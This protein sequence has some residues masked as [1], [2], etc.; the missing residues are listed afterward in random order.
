MSVSSI[1]GGPSSYRVPTSVEPT[2]TAASLATAKSLLESH[3]A[4]A[5]AL[6]NLTGRDG[7]ET[8]LGTSPVSQPG[9]IQDHKLA[10]LKQMGDMML[11]L[12][13]MMAV[14]SG[15]SLPPSA[16]GGTEVPDLGGGAGG[17]AL[18]PESLGDGIGDAVGQQIGQALG[19]GDF[20]KLLGDAFGQVFG[21]KLTEALKAQDGEAL[22]GKIF[23]AIQGLMEQQKNNKR[24]IANTLLDTS[25]KLKQLLGN[26]QAGNLKDTAEKLGQ[27]FGEASQKVQDLSN[28]NPVE[29]LGQAIAKLLTQGLQTP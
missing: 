5:Q 6:R 2:V 26:H 10:L 22:R 29:L 7:F 13:Q 3:A 23:E 20:G 1:P 8:N 16:P 28:K 17:G 11:S 24:E 18:S 25:E 27:I 15:Q 4:M 21:D 12:Q 14:L 19:G 9:G